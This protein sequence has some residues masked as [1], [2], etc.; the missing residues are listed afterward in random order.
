MSLRIGHR[1]HNNFLMKIAQTRREMNIASPEDRVHQKIN[2]INLFKNSAHL[3]G[4]RENRPILRAENLKERFE[5]IKRNISGR[6]QNLHQQNRVGRL[7][8]N[9][10][11][12]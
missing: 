2:E 9:Q 6:R 10:L 7:V 4:G 8:Q 11:I 5:G 12:F 1:N 3:R